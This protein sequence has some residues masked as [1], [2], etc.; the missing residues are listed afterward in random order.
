M[1]YVKRD[2]QVD[3]KFEGDLIA[4][5][6]SRS[7]NGPNQNRWTEMKLYKTKSGKFVI[8]IAGITIWQGEHDRYS[9]YTCKD[10]NE[11]VKALIDHNEGELSWLAK[12]LLGEAGIDSAEEV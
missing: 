3:L 6:S 5:A 11:V 12:E 10:E 1:T 9:G 8:G 2:E 7:V 4:K